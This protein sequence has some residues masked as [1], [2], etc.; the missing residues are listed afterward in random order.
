MISS[1]TLL[2]CDIVLKRYMHVLSE[3]PNVTTPEYRL[4][5]ANAH[6]DVK[7]ARDLEFLGIEEAIRQI[8]TEVDQASLLWITAKE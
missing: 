7:R 2:M 8:P 4:L 5:I 1:G 6:A 3:E